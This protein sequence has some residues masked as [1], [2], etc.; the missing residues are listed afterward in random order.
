[1]IALEF[2]FFLLDKHS[3]LYSDRVRSV[4]TNLLV[5]SLHKS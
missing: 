1:M 4:M 3:L 5:R 2:H